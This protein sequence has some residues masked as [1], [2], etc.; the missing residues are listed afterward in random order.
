VGKEISEGSV[1]SFVA[2]SGVVPHEH[3]FDLFLVDLASVSEFGLG[4]VAPVEASVVVSLEDIVG[5]WSGVIY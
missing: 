2:G 3:G 1:C 5:Y 4:S